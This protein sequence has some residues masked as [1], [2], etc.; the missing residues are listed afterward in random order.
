MEDILECNVIRPFQV[1]NSLPKR[2]V[3]SCI[4]RLFDPLGFLSPVLIRPKVL[5]QKTWTLKLEW[6]A[7]LPTD[8]EKEF[9][10]WLY[11]IALLDQVMIPR[12][13]Y[14][15]CERD[16][17]LH[18]FCD[19][20]CE[21]YA[22]VAFARSVVQDT[23]R[24]VFLWAK[25]RVAPWKR[26]TITWITRAQTWNTFVKKRVTEIRNLTD[27]K[28]RVHIS[29]DENPADLPSRGCS[30]ARYLKT[31]WWKGPHWSYEDPGDWPKT[32]LM[33]NKE[34]VNME[35]TECVLTEVALERRCFSTNFSSYPSNLRV[36]EWIER[37]SSRSCKRG[38][39]AGSLSAEEIEQAERTMVGIIQREAFEPGK[40]YGKNLRVG[41]FSDGLLYVESKLLYSEESEH[42][43]RPFLLPHKHPLVDLMIREEHLRNNHAGTHILMSIMRE[44]F[45]IIKS[46]KTIG[47]IVRGCVKC[48]RFDQRPIRRRFWTYF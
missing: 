9:R 30:A 44:K 7:Q 19:A 23:V 47:R 34:E 28:S 13:L 16:V 35:S 2:T 46:R 4:Q 41:V 25:A 15:D 45:W 5:L 32:E 11:K 40:T 6:D 42:F 12:C 39:C 43:R 21:A 14:L 31:E 1:P 27:V 48:R 33:V 18:V 37:F 20:S 36:I 24:V 22:S 29:G 3:L 17:Q 38:I 8:T 26:I 10:S